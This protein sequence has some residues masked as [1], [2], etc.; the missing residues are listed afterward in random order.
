[1]RREKHKKVYR[2]MKS[3]IGVTI[4]AVIIVGLAGVVGAAGEEPPFKGVTIT[5]AVHSGHHA[6]PWYNEMK[7]M[8]KTL[9]IKLNVVEMTEEDIYSKELL[10][11][12]TGTGA[13]DIV[14]YNSAWI[15]DYE[16]YLL[17]LDKFILNGGDEFAFGDILPG[18]RYYQNMWGGK[19]YSVTLDG[20]TFLLYY[21][22]DLF[23]N[24]EEKAAFKAKYGY[25]LTPPKTWK[26]V[27][28]IAKFFTRKK[29]E[30]L[31]GSTLLKNF[32]GY[33]D[34]AK[35]GRVYYWY[36]FRYIP[37]SAPNPN[38][39]DPK[40]MKPL[41]NSPNAISALENM[42]ECLRYSPPGVLGWE[43]DELWSAAMKDG[44]VA[45][46]IHWT[47]E[48]KRLNEVPPL[49]VE[50]PPTP[51]LGIAPTPGVIKNGILYQ[52]TLVDSAWVASICKD[53]KHPKAAW[54]VLNYMFRPG[55]VSLRNVMDPN[56]GWDA[57]RY[58]HVNSPLW[59]V[60]VPGIER[61]LNVEL[62]ALEQGYPCL[63]IP[64]AYEYMDSLDM[65][66]SKY[67]AGETP[68]AKEALGAVAKEWNRITKKFGLEK[69]KEFYRKMWSF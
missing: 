14:Q 39:F 58:S 4:I 25:E 15:G 31:A 30:K 57:S 52:Y 3:F 38:Y 24:P 64:G 32:Y 62:K 33:A 26:Q 50:N 2:G 36:L 61:Y 22:A 12:T 1:M 29:G 56:T 9:G 65:N 47:D 28:D 66:I 59:R 37:F 60:K 8:E 10:E 51:K 18:F 63:K 44:I 49:P 20:D 43:W 13:Y 48:G 17:P 34:Q 41:I 19:I 55:A 21:R 45:M 35:R 5:V 68:T 11:L 53:S 67:L 69:Q 42:K 27:L 46:W 54:A 7:N 16:P 6:T 23:E 40:T